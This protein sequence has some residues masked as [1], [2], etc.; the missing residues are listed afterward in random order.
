MDVIKTQLMNKL[1]WE[2]EGA[3]WEGHKKA[4]FVEVAKDRLR[5][6][7]ANVLL[8]SGDYELVCQ[9][10]KLLEKLA[11]FSY[12]IVGKASV[13]EATE[14][15]PDEVDT[16]W[17]KLVECERLILITDIVAMIPVFPKGAPP[18]PAVAKTDTIYLEILKAE[19]QNK[20]IPD[21][22][23]QFLIAGEVEPRAKI[24][25]FFQVHDPDKPIV[26]IDQM[27]SDRTILGWSA[28]EEYVCVTRK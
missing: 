6:M 3:D 5:T 21:E 22:I 14:A 13:I 27:L 24:K 20:R 8:Q 26:E 9:F 10:V 7:Q 19:R 4:R 16:M 18:P 11:C 28:P 12:G 25:A 1:V 23:L 17:D 15:A 2:S